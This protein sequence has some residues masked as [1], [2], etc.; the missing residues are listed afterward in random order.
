MGVQVSD[1]WKPQGTTGRLAYLGWGVG[2]MALKYNLDRFTAAAFGVSPWYWASYWHPWQGSIASIPLSRQKFLFTLLTLALPFVGAGIV[3]TVRR[4]RDAQW[5]TWLACLFFVPAVN[6]LFFLC[7][8]LA[9]SRLTPLLLDTSRRGKRWLVFSDPVASALAGLGLTL[10]L[11]VSLITF[12]TVFLQSYGWGLFVGVPFFMGLLSALVHSAA[13]QRSWVS[14]ATVAMLSVLLA[15]IAL[16]C[17]AVEGVICVLMAAPLAV[18]LAVLGASVAYCIQSTRWSHRETGAL[19]GAAWLAL[20][21]LMVGEVRFAPPRPE[22][23]ATTRIIIAAPPEVVWRNV[24]A[25]SELPPPRELIFRS[26]IAY[27]VRARIRGHGVGAI[28]HCEF[29]T[30]PFVEPIT[31]W[32]DAHR[33]AFDVT[34]Q[35]PPMEELSPYPYLHPPHLD[36]FFHSRH[37]QFLLTALPDGRTQLDGTTWYE[38]NLWPNIY[39]RVWSDYLVHRIHSRVLEHIKAES[40]AAAKV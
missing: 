6:L 38:Q 31:V 25:F 5:P 13:A 19:Y 8:G 34:E 39:W 3:L 27:P 30:G 21:V 23:E 18:P 1:L 32:D 26:G 40:E 29:S 14:C 35:P 10:L 15:G 16:V 2:L 28:R 4:L 11:A 17:L 24:V 7:L 20:P 12:G 36:G 33:L 22:I 37:G 9:P